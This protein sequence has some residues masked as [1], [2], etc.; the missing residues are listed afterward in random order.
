MS[1]PTWTGDTMGNVFHI[2][3][4][5]FHD[6]PEEPIE[7]FMEYVNGVEMRRVHH[8]GGGPFNDEGWER[9]DRDHSTDRTEV[10]DEPFSGLE[11]IN[12]Q[13]EF[14]AQAIDAREFETVWLKALGGR[15]PE[16]DSW[17]IQELVNMTR[18]AYRV[19]TR[20]RLKTGRDAGWLLY[21]KLLQVLDLFT[22]FSAAEWDEWV[23]KEFES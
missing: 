17:K 10:S 18:D 5:W 9:A 14:A 4:R 15:K 12:A 19:A 7:L 21:Q 1:N 11:A 8:F 23:Q 13:A 3:C 6:Y 16:T 20:G 22:E 2:A